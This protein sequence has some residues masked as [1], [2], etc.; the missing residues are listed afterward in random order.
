MRLNIQPLVLLLAFSHFTLSSP[1]SLPSPLPII[2]PLHTGTAGSKSCH[3]PSLP[4]LSLSPPGIQHTKPVCY[5]L[6]AT[7]ECGI[8]VANKDDRCEARLYSVSNCGGP[9]QEE[10]GPWYQ[11]T[12]VF[13]PE[14][15]PVG[16]MWR[17]VSVRC[18]VVKDV[19]TGV[20]GA[21]EKLLNGA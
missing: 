21:A 5:T 18:G 15:R 9:E 1:K 10:E 13:M 11:N 17:S 2:A 4:P 19:D 7:A 16:G 8:F 6:P 20:I 14:I 12:A 3:G